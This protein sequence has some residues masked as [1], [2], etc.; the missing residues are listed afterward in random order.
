MRRFVQRRLQ[1]GTCGKAVGQQLALGIAAVDTSREN[2]MNLTRT[3]VRTSPLAPVILLLAILVAWILVLA[4][5]IALCRAAR[6]GDRQRTVSPPG[7]RLSV[8]GWA[9][10]ARSRGH[11]SAT[12][13][14]TQTTPGAAPERRGG[15][16]HIER[17]HDRLT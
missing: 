7:R 3:T 5:T 9:R 10:I 12:E 4:L 2:L 11:R 17:S 1:T 15:H 14:P 13:H 16:T 6:I 8:R